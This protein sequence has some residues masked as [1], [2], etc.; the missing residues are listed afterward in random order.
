MAVRQ[1]IEKVIYGKDNI[2]VR[3]RWG[4]SPDGKEATELPSSASTPGLSAPPAVRPPEKEKRP[5]PLLGTDPLFQFATD[6]LWSK[7]SRP[8]TIDLNVPNISHGYWENYEL[9]GE[10]NLR[11]TL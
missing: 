8:Q 9:T 2:T 11:P 6:K 7:I 3:F 4:L 1:G 10:Y 5:A